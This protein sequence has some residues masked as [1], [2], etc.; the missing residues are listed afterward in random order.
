MLICTGCNIEYEEDKKY[1][2]FCGDPLVPK[3]EPASTQKK[4]NKNED[5]RSDENLFCPHCKLSYEFGSSCIQCGSP[6]T[7][8]SPPQ[9]E[10]EPKIAHP[11]QV[12]E[13]PYEEERSQKKQTEP[14]PKNLICPACKIAY[15]SGNYCI[16]CGAALITQISTELKQEPEIVSSPEEKGK[17]SPLETLQEQLIQAPRQNLICPDC[18]IIYERGDTCIRCGSALVSQIQSQEGER[19]KSPEPQEVIPF[20]PESDDGRLLRG[21]SKKPF[22]SDT[23]EWDWGIFEQVKKKEVGVTQLPK[24]V[25]KEEQAQPHA[26]EQP[27]KKST[28]E[29]ER[30]LILPQKRKKDY[31]RLFME[32]GSITLMVV[33]GGYFLWSIFSHL[34]KQP[35]PASPTFKEES[36]QGLPRST[37]PTVPTTSMT[38]SEGSQN[39]APTPPLPLTASETSHEEIQKIEDIKILLENIRQANLQ[40]NI[41]LFISCYAIDFKD[42]EGK[43]KATLTYWKN[44]DYLDLSYELKDPSIS[45][46][47]AKARVEWLIKISPKT[48]GHSQEIKTL[49]DVL[50]KREESGWKIKEVKQMG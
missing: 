50:L 32:I 17:T 8:Q 34:T 39:T 1:C 11:P 23:D 26:P 33:A 49:L 24:P 37:S 25:Y 41:D 40:K 44:F 16:K 3:T 30:R 7:H 47:S 38:E 31:R 10:E 27:A 45:V 19:S 18:K 22:F 13:K 6:L 12:E 5:E 28:D 15:E 43:K 29:L 36:S 9:T 21:E 46:D 4:V 20:I 2:K 48:G 14:S 42:R 35:E